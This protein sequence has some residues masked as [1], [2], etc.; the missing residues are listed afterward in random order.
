MAGRAFSR[1]TMMPLPDDFGLDPA[2]AA[3]VKKVGVKG[4]AFDKEVE[5]MLKNTMVHAHRHSA[6]AQKLGKTMRAYQHNWPPNYADGHYVDATREGDDVIFKNSWPQG[7]DAAYKVN[8]PEWKD[9]PWDET[10][11]D[12]KAEQAGPGKV[13]PG[14]KKE[15]AETSWIPKYKPNK[16]KP[17]TDLTRFLSATERAIEDWKERA[18]S[19]KLLCKQDVAWLEIPTVK[20]AVGRL[21]QNTAA[22]AFVIDVNATQAP[23]WSCN[24]ASSAA[25]T[26]VAKVIN[27]IT[28]SRTSANSIKIDGA[29]VV[30][31]P[32]LNTSIFVHVAPQPSRSATWSVADAL[33]RKEAKNARHK[34]FFVLNDEV[35][36][37]REFAANRAVILQSVHNLFGADDMVEELVVEDDW[38][39]GLRI[40]LPFTCGNRITVFKKLSANAMS[41][42]GIML[43]FNYGGHIKVENDENLRAVAIAIDLRKRFLAQF[44]ECLKSCTIYLR[45]KYAGVIVQEKDSSKGHFRQFITVDLSFDPNQPEPIRLPTVITKMINQD[46]DLLVRVV[47][48]VDGKQE[49]REVQPNEVAFRRVLRL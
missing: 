28:V 40:N 36:V 13:K 11:W 49:I 34:L 25:A 1:N 44:S 41:A 42:E 27:Q 26:A 9:T 8:I 23:T 10:P 48:Q 33:L 12:E 4:S 15:E 5:Q 16:P 20:A 39:M 30:V 32:D 21:L 14:S 18:A 45:S 22:V 29:I 2:T 38:Q 6:A 31:H 46:Y 47:K 37:S 24:T 35:V 19:Y 3:V 7:D 17:A 43:T